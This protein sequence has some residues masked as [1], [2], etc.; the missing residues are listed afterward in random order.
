MEIRIAE[1][2]LTIIAKTLKEVKDLDRVMKSNLELITYAEG[3]FS[4]HRFLEI[5]LSPKQ[6][7]VKKK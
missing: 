5:K 7:G 2:R 1:D 6:T 3:G 4:G